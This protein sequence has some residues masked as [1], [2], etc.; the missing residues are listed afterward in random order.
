[1]DKPDTDGTPVSHRHECL[2][3]GLK[4]VDTAE[5]RQVGCPTCASGLVAAEGGHGIYQGGA[6]GG[7][8]ASQ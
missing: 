5:D 2:C 3:H 7:D 8:E 6:A 1:M 4:S